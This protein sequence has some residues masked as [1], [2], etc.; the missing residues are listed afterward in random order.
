MCLF[1]ILPGVLT[2]QDKTTFS[3]SFATNVGISPEN[4]S[5]TILQLY[6]LES[7]GEMKHTLFVETTQVCIL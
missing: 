1:T 2:G 6:N 3:P 5:L 4:V 7:V